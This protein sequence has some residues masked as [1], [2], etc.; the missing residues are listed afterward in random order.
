MSKIYPPIVVEKGEELIE[1]LKESNFFKDYEINNME[2]VRNHILDD[3]T[4]KFINGLIDDDFEEMY[5][6]E[7]FEQLLKELVAG[8][9]L[10]ELKE[11]GLVN[12]YQDEE[13]EEMFFLTEKGKQIMRETGE[14]II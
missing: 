9:V 10:H 1:G 3:L 7:E 13:T 2:F 12:S 6:E 4:E 11:K 14:D 5:K 8:S